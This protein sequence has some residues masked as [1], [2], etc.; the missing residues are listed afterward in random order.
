MTERLTVKGQYL[1]REGQSPEYFY[2]IL[3]GDFVICKDFVHEE[4]NTSTNLVDTGNNQKVAC[5][6]AFSEFGDDTID[7]DSLQAQQNTLV[8]CKTLVL[9]KKTRGDVWGEVELILKID[10]KYDFRCIS[11]QGR[12][13]E[14]HRSD[15]EVWLSA[16]NALLSNMVA[17]SKEI[18]RYFDALMA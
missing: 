7:K 18:F 9:D 16:D 3:E 14:L 5:T 8:A 12:L 13:W 4:K 17:K 1:F 15:F 6:E 10:R 2:V 11:T